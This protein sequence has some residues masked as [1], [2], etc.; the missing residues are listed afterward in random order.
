RYPSQLKG[1]IYIPGIN[2]ILMDGSILVILIFRESSTMEGAYGLAITFDMLM[3]TSLLVFYFSIY[4]K[5]TF[6]S[7][8]LALLF[9]TLEGMFLVSNLIKFPHGGWFSFGIAAILFWVLFIQLRARGLR[10]QHTE[11]VDLKHYEDMIR[12]L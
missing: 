8:A 11:F 12:D 4:K 6:R 1:Q 7:L 10:T 2:W 9:F 5:S 3:T